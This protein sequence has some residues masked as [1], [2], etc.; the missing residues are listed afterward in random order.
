MNSQHGLTIAI[1]NWNH[2]LLL[3][4][5]ILSGL[6][7]VQELRWLGIPGEV[8]IV[9]D[10]SRDGSLTLLRQ[11]EAEYHEAG[12]RVIALAQNAGLAS[13]RNQ[14]LYHSKYRYIAFVDAD[15]EIVPENAP[16]FLETL[17]T[18]GASAAYGTLIMRPP[19]STTGYYAI[20]NE[21]IQDRIFQ[22]NYVDALAMFDRYHLIDIGG[23]ESS[24]PSWEDYALMLH[25]L[26]TGRLS[27]FVPV[28]F[29]YYY[30]IPGSMITQTTEE[31][32]T[33]GLTNRIQRIFNQLGIRDQLPL[34]SR[35]KRFHP[36][37]GYF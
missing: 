37:F 3:P 17:R 20:N 26:A 8:L 6:K 33:A 27:V 15:N 25:L 10:H 16:L 22:S 31:N 11:L 32:K 7:T 9:D 5:A 13:T 18:T 29:G 30:I 14:A 21:S 1:P 19:A 36:A 35:M 2:E 12:L 28:V 24:C 4:R 23:Y 34:E